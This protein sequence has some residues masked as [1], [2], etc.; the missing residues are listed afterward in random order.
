M[1]DEQ[2][3]KLHLAW[4]RSTSLDDKLDAAT[5]LSTTRELREM[6]WR[7]T[8]VAAGSPRGPRV[9]DGV[10]VYCIPQPDIYLMRRLAM[11]YR[12]F[13]FLS[14]QMDDIDVVIFHEL[15]LPILWMLQFKRRLTGKRAPLLVMDT[16]T[17]PM[18][19]ETKET[20]KDRLR[21]AFRGLANNWA[22]RW[23]DGRLAI[24]QRMAEV[25]RIPPGKLWGVWPSGVDPAPFLPAQEMRR[26][27]EPDEPVKL[28]Y[29]GCMH[30]ERNLMTMSKAVVRANAEG[31]NF[32]LILIGD[33]NERDDLADFAADTEGQVRVLDPVPHAQ[34]PSVLA[35][36][37]IGVL[38][39]PDEIKFQVS[40]PIKLFEY[41]A[42]G[43]P[44]L[45]TQIACHTDVLGGGD[46]VFWAEHSD[47]E[48]LLDALRMAWQSRKMLAAMGVQSAEAVGNWTWHASA[49]KLCRALESG[50]ASAGRPVSVR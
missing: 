32:Q 8:L 50:L 12:I 30:Y 22:N 6:G 42:A 9:I 18:S 33:G 14:P 39:F 5:W 3:N 1:S 38:A 37:H 44:I 23:A 28:I 11:F 35:D 2:T 45:A 25:L 49:E 10:E 40:S 4:I 24:T 29:I 46:Y 47:E 13:D 20:W 36:A 41:M 27:P 34:M 21:R 15:T 31:L 19:P 48:G 17:L 43:M 16:R 26:W 7:V